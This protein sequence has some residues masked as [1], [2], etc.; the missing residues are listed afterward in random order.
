MRRWIP[1]LVSLAFSATLLLGINRIVERKR[2]TDEIDRLRTALYSARQASVRCQGSLANSE[3]GL[4]AFDDAVRDLRA[5]VD[6]FEALDP[7]GVPEADYEAY[8]ESFE[9]YNDSVAAREGRVQRLRSAEAACRTVIQEHNALSDSL[10]SVLDENG[11]IRT[12]S[13]E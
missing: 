5:R 7:R 2:L 8:M 12:D 3:A 11:L 10:R 4:R 9:G 6:S 1:I 13:T